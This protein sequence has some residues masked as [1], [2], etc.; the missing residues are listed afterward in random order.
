M[1]RRGL[2][3]IAQLVER[4]IGN[5]EVTGPSPVISFQKHSKIMVF[6]CFFCHKLPQVNS[7]NV[8][9]LHFIF[10]SGFF[11]C[12]LIFVLTRFSALSVDLGSL[13]KSLAIS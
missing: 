13:P 8:R 7:G 12:F 11:N 5:A 9:I 6:G 3:A 1:C 10:Y 2:A 4:R